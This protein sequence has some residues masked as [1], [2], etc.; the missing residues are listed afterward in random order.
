MHR[1]TCSK[2]WDTLLKKC[3]VGPWYLALNRP[4]NAAN[5]AVS[6]TYTLKKKSGGPCPWTPL[7]TCRH[8]NVTSL[9][10]DINKLLDP[11]L[12][13]QDFQSKTK[14][15]KGIFHTLNSMNIKLEPGTC[16]RSSVR[17]LTILFCIASLYSK[18][19]L[20]HRF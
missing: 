3:Q 2:W 16:S 10:S 4:E 15:W 18:F 20:L 12:K 6:E 5:S 7:Q 9:L 8:K 17:R 19:P 14:I 1:N 11:S 13:L